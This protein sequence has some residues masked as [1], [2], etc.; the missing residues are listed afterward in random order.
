MTVSIQPL[1]EVSTRARNALLKELGVA[2][3]LRFFAQFRAGSGNYT[4]EREHLFQGESVKDIIS[5]IKA[6]KNRRA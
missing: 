3:T 4:E 6:R 5:E 1:S 2:D